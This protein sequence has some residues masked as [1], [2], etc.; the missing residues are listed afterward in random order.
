MPRA[1][2]QEFSI[3]HDGNKRTDL[4]IESQFAAA[5]DERQ[6]PIVAAAD[7]ARLLAAEVAA[8]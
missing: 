8:I 7:A 3:V 2:V 4:F 1:S 6:G 5:T